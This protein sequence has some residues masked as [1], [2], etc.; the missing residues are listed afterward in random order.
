MSDV[1]ERSRLERL[2]TGRDAWDGG[3][4]VSMRAILGSRAGYAAVSRLQKKTAALA[5]KLWS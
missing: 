3:V 4:V 5:G 1:E 2:E